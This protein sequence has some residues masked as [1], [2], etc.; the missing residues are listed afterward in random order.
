MLRKCV[1]THLQK[2]ISKISGTPLKGTSR[3]GERKEEQ[4]P[5]VTGHVDGDPKIVRT[6]PKTSRCVDGSVF[7]LKIRQRANSCCNNSIVNN[8][9]KQLLYEHEVHF[10][11]D[12]TSV[13]IIL[14][15][16]N[17]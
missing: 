16:G 14:N 6:H 5:G 8:S 13:R 17:N 4:V 12:V 10:F 3:E 15:D 9:L 1:E 11:F 7:D 2:C